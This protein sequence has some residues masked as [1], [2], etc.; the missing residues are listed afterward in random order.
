[1]TSL[2][3]KFSHSHMLVFNPRII[4]TKPNATPWSRRSH[5]PDINLPARLLPHQQIKCTFKHQFSF[6]QGSSNSSLLKLI[7]TKQNNGMWFSRYFQKSCLKGHSLKKIRK[8]THE[9]ATTR[10]TD[11][12]EESRVGGVWCGRSRTHCSAAGSRWPDATPCRSGPLIGCPFPW[13]QSTPNQQFFWGNNSETGFGII[14]LPWKHELKQ[15]LS[16]SWNLWSPQIRMTWC[17]NKCW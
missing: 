7:I 2:P 9:R 1:M 3:F 6:S 14:P 17:V 11:M 12:G 16:F 5:T 13:Q 10:A 15:M 4:P 8:C